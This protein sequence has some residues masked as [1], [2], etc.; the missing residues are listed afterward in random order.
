MCTYGCLIHVVVWQKPTQSCKAI[1]LQL[2]MLLKNTHLKKKILTFVGLAGHIG[3]STKWAS[4]YCF[5]R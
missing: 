5:S 1:I 3:S 4:R 2:K